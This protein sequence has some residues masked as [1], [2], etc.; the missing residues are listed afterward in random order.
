[1]NW[2]WKQHFIR[3]TY[4]VGF[5]ILFEA[6]ILAGWYIALEGDPYFWPLGILSAFI[7]HVLI[8]TKIDLLHEYHHHHNGK[9]GHQDHKAP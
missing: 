8:F 4:K 3:N 9:K 6:S 7:I 2:K 1:M 5:H